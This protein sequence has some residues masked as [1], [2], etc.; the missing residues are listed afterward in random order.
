MEFVRLRRLR[1]TEAIRSLISQTQILPQNLIM[2][3]FVMEGKHKK[4]HISS[5][6]GVYRLSIDK[7]IEDIKEAKDLGIKAILLFG[8]CRHKDEKAS[9]AYAKDGLIHRAIRQIKKEVEDTVVITDVCL[10][11]Y[12]S[13]GHCGI[14]KTKK[15]ARPGKAKRAGETRVQKPEKYIDNDA[16]IKVLAKI[17]VSHAQAGADIMA[18]SAMMDGQVKAIRENL[19]KAGFSEV[20]IMSYSAKFASAFYGPFREALDSSPQFGN[21]QTY[22]MD[23]RNSD[24]ALREIEEDIQEGADIVMIKPALAYLDIIQTASQKF[25]LPIAAYSVSGEYAMMKAY[26]QKPARPGKAKRAGETR[27]QKPETGKEKEL[28]LEI[29]TAIKRAGARVI[30]TYWAKDLARWLKVSL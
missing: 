25:N 7:L 27:V 18:P 21:R 11:G 1:R 3:Y 20:A 26:C 6:P 10:C 8:I 4:E 2:P 30:I 13:H 5:M 24:E 29:M 17:A 19:D 14:V 12:T 15:P 28:V 9:Q 22:Q 16:T 23:S